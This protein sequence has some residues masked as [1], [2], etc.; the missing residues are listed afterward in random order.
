V[1]LVYAATVA[2]LGVFFGA[3]FADPD[4]AA[5]VGVVTTLV[6]AALGGCWWPIEVVSEPLKA[7]SFIVP[8]GWAMRALHGTISFGYAVD[9]LALP[10]VVLAV[11]AAAFTLLA[12]LSL[13]LD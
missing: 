2:P 11:F 9:A 3:R 6:F 10:L 13:R 4:R 1:L 5:S 8:T 7:A 12:A